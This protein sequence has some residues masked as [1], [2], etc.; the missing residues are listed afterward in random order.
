MYQCLEFILIRYIDIEATRNVFT[1]ISQSSRTFLETLEGLK[2]SI[3]LYE[4]FR[5]VLKCVEVN[6][7]HFEHL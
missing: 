7:N 5:S 3:I 4:N 2:N 6:V 1:V